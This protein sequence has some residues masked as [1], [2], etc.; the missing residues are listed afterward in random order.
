M[1]NKLVRIT[2]K[3]LSVVAR[4][5]PQP[6]LKGG[7]LGGPMK[8]QARRAS[9][10][11]E[12]SLACASGLYC[13]FIRPGWGGGRGERGEPRLATKL[14]HQW[15]KATGVATLPLAAMYT[16]KLPF[17]VDIGSPQSDSRAKGRLRS[18][19]CNDQ[20]TTALAPLLHS[21]PLLGEPLKL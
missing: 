13:D 5:P 12:S 7:G 14:L 6:A 20:A 3:T 8:I 9:E 1:V 16:N 18:L 10:G 21:D 2:R 15:P 4:P 17:G 19:F 11:S